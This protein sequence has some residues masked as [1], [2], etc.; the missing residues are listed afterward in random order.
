LTFFRDRIMG[1]AADR[2]LGVGDVLVLC[3]DRLSPTN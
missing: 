3:R 1:D 2:P